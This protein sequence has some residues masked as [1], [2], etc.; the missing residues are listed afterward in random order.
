ME[1]KIY[2]VFISS[3]YTDLQDERRAVAEAISKSGQIPAGMEYFPASSQ[4]QFEYIK[5]I[6]DRCDYYVLLIAGKYGSLAPSGI[7]FTE[8]EYRYAVSIG[9][10]VL[11][12]LFRD[13]GKI[14]S[15]KVEKDKPQRDMLDAF[16]NEVAK[17]RVVD[18]WE[19]TK[20]LPGKV[21]I[22]VAQEINLN[23]GI[24]WVRGDQAIDPKIYEENERLRRK[25]L[26]LE[27]E[28]KPLEF[29]FPT[30]IESIETTV[31]FETKLQTKRSQGPNHSYT[32]ESEELRNFEITWKDLFKLSSRIL[33][34]S[35]TAREFNE[36]LESVI[37]NEILNINREN[38][39]KN[40]LILLSIRYTDI[41]NQFICYGLV[42][43]KEEK[44]RS[45]GPLVLIGTHKIVIYI[46]TEKGKRFRAFLSAKLTPL[47]PHPRLM[48]EK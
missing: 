13:I 44:E 39:K 2:Q 35:A 34:G 6:I 37:L 19:D 4:Q 27:S 23:P 18:F 15:N 24:G 11:A 25:I 22:A 45:T 40:S 8:E 3:T 46:L 38:N 32:L 29:N 1:N 41:I 9:I 42:D 7:S 26:E 36:E 10:P 47:S 30:N 21:V 48:G 5:R 20:E 33:L 31:K 16:R 12:F 14:A 17:S 43:S 28:G